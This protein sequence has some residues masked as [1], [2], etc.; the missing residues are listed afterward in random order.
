MADHLLRLADL[1]FSY[2]DGTEALCGVDLSLASGER[3]AVLGPNG[4]GK[5]T[6][7]L[8]MVGVVEADGD[9]EI[10]G[11]R[12]GPDTI[13]DVRRL[14][15][16]VFQDT[17][18]QLFMP[19]VGEDVAFGPA[20]SGL[21]GEALEH[22]VLSAM[23]AVDIADHR[24]RVPHHLSS[25]EARRAAIATVLSMKPKLLAFDEPTANLDP[26]G[27]NE[28]GELLL[29]LDTTVL[30]VTHDLPFALRVCERSVILDEGRVVADGATSEILADAE[31]LRRHR[32]ELPYGF[33][34]G[35]V[36]K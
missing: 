32:L 23:Q 30:V 3:V 20:N 11:I 21:S 31:L 14:I 29:D 5:T 25:G 19:T 28:L 7:L 15:G 4:A 18:D 26:K 33:D 16:L 27:E 6:L 1:T 34:P 24:S 36:Q 13:A 35:S 12:L 10:D 22:R 9:V 8:A 17:D 2:A